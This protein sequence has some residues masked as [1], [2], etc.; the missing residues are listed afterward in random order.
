[1]CVSNPRNES[2]RKYTQGLSNQFFGNPNVKLFAIQGANKK[3]KKL[4]GTSSPSPTASG[5]GG[6]GGGGGIRAGVSGA[7]GVGGVSTG[8]YGNVKSR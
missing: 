2:E 4:G 1:M 5:G 7:S 8:L 6:Q 3:S